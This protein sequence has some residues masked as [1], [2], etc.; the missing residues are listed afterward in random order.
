[1]TP[2]ADLAYLIGYEPIVTER[3]TLLVVGT[4]GH[5]AL[6]APRLERGEAEKARGAAAVAISDWSDGSDQFAAAAQLLGANA[7]Y[8]ITDTTMALHVLGLQ[9]ARP[10]TQ[11]VAMSVALPLLGAV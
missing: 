2:G 5:A 4:D 8:A 6:L 7:R 1:M 3:L 9:R 11:Y 10:D